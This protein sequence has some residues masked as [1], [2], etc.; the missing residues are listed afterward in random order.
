ML[1]FAFEF[2]TPLKNAALSQ[3]GAGS[4]V[5]YASSVIWAIALSGGF[6]A[7]LIYAIYLLARNRTIS[8]FSIKGT[9]IYFLW[10]L[11][12]G[13]IFY[14]SLLCY[15]LAA[16]ALGNAGTT[17]GWLIFT[18]G[19]IITANIWGVITSEWAGVPKRE[20][21]KMVIGSLLLISA[22]FLVSYGNKLL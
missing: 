4:N 21:R 7:F 17:T 12:M 19:A 16:S 3:L 20:M 6:L 14:S 8:N 10:A 22:V 2:G 9:R 13:I 5:F 18:A 11:L 15:G 1:N